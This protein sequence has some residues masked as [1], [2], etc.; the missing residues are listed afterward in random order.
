MR[1]VPF[2]EGGRLKCLHKSLPAG[3]KAQPFEVDDTHSLKPSL[4][5]R[6]ESYGLPLKHIEAIDKIKPPKTQKKRR[7][8]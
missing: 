7:R 3:D 2:K 4:S 1:K 6:L 5:S 8:R